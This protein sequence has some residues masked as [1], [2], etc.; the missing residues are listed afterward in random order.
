MNYAL[1]EN[2]VVSNIIALRS[3]NA[4]DFPGAVALYDRPAGIGDSY[5]DGKFY[6]D[7][8]EVLTAAEEIAA[9]RAA[10]ETLGVET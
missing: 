10:L 8:A 2:G 3:S 9:M 5:Q 4:A 1:I 7:G 6:R